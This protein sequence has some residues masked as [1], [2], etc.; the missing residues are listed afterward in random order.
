M[1]GTIPPTTKKR[2]Q[3]HM[4]K[5]WKNSPRPRNNTI[6]M[7]LKRLERIHDALLHSVLENSKKHSLSD[8]EELRMSIEELKQL[9][10][11][12]RGE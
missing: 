2:G 3:I 7:E 8:L 1:R 6:E 12:E 9:I 4:S 11:E 10:T 5:F